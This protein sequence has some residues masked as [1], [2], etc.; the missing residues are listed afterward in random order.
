MLMQGEVINLD[1]DKEY[2]VVFSTNFENSNYVYAINNSDIEDVTFFKCEDD[3]VYEVE[4]SD[5]NLKLMNLFYEFA[6]K[7]L[8]NG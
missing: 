5:M 1:N 6:K 8:K 3:S 2:T 4:D 7:E